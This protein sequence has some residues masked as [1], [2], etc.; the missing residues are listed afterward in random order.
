MSVYQGS[1][2]CLTTLGL[3]SI[4]EL[5]ETGLMNILEHTGPAL[6]KLNVF[7]CPRLTDSFL[8]SLQTTYN[9]NN[10]AKLVV[11]RVPELNWELEDPWE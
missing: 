9:D 1:L 10:H 4:Y 8:E 5:T 2:P 3:E 7:D 6:E 11:S